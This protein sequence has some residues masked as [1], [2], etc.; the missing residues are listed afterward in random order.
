MKRRPSGRK[1]GLQFRA[2]LR[3]WFSALA[4]ARQPSQRSSGLKMRSHHDSGPPL[5]SVAAQSVPRP[6]VASFS[7]SC[8]GK[9]D[10][11]AVGRQNGDVAP[12][13]FGAN[14]RPE[15][16]ATRFSF[17]ALT[18][19]DI[20]RCGRRREMAMGSVERPWFASVPRSP[21]GGSPHVFVRRATL[22]AAARWSDPLPRP[23][24]RKLEH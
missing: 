10:V 7:S 18:A 4:A 20:A 17:A 1:L 15:R 12:A 23:G 8:S 11:P 2:P 24:K 16:V 22:A 9:T 19:A 3:S 13:V 14:R 21:S 6:P 5:L